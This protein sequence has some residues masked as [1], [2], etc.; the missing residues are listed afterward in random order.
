[1]NQKFKNFGVVFN[2]SDIDRTE[3]FYRD[4]LGIELERQPGG[5]HGDWLM[6]VFDNGLELMFFE[7]E[8]TIG[9]S[10]IVVFELEE[11][12][13]ES[14]VEEMAKEGVEIVT[15]VTEAPGG[16]SVDFRDP[17]GHPMAFFQS[18]NLPLQRG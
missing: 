13:I 7:G 3:R 15:P 4:I 18:E 2:V 1:M 8:E 6:G 16:W 17:D 9:R 11:G 5:D 14:I 12:Y 10:P